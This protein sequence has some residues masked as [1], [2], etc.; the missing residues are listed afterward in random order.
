MLDFCFA[1][2]ASLQYI[3]TNCSYWQQIGTPENKFFPCLCPAGSKSLILAV[4]RDEFFGTR[5]ASIFVKTTV[6]HMLKS[7]QKHRVKV[8]TAQ[9]IA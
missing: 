6:R 1:F 2:K 3:C 9:L 5:D 8:S 7:L 4:S